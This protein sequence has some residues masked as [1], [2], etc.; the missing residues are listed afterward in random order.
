MD[1][2][3]AI[4]LGGISIAYLVLKKVNK[5]RRLKRAMWMKN[6]FQT[7]N[8]CILKDLEGNNDVLFKNFTRM[9][10]NNFLNILHMV[11]P[12][13]EKSDSHFRQ[14]IPAEVRLAITLRFLA[15]GD[16]YSSLMYLFRVSKQSISVI[17]PQVLKAIITSLKQHVKV[18]NKLNSIFL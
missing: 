9:S 17:V 12:L 14:A 8:F 2:G 7:R 18:N 15:T 16:S 4:L 11:R 13:I 5:R 10:K 6:Y 1:E 3:D